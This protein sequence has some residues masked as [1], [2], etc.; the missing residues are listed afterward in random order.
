MKL[1][2]DN[3]SKNYG[4]KQALTGFSAELTDGVYA[5][6]GPNGAGKSTLMNIITEII[7]PSSGD[8]Y[9][10]GKSIYRIGDE[11]RNTL[12]FL[13][14][15]PGLYKSF[16]ARAF[17]A[18]I[19]R[20]KGMKDRR[21]IDE[22]VGSLLERVNLTADADRKIGTFSGGMKQRVGIAQA[23]LG[24]PKLI[25]L[26]EPTAGLDP[27]ERIRFRNIISEI[28]FDSI[29][30]LATH[31]V[32]DVAQIAKQAMLLGDGRLIANADVDTLTRAID[33]SVWQVTCGEREY[34]RYET[35]YKISA[36]TRYDNS[37][38]LRILSDTKPE[39]ECMQVQPTLED[40]YLHHFGQSGGE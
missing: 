12:G 40:V 14:Q 16:T 8:I 36:V 26:D 35:A 4:E 21:E 37:L 33:G 15:S 20:L 39:G 13:P 24:S 18:Y 5:L 7:K 1:L 29:V 27:S 17:L 22:Q 28:G 32:S 25:I 31:I 3:V 30:I 2:I 38:R 9:W 6:L 34:E 19:A 23:M 11:L 10:N